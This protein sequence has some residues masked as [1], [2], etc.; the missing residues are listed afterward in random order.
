M[1]SY[2]F[3]FSL[4]EE[5]DPEVLPLSFETSCI[6]VQLLVVEVAE[7]LLSRDAVWL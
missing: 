2:T 7:K 1:L 3:F 6:V 4:Y 5:S